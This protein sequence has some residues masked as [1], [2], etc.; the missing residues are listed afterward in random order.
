M[1]N[2]STVIIDGKEISKETLENLC[3][4]KGDDE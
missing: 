3:D 4:N 1:N 2:E